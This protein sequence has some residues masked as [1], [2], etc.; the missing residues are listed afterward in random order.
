MNLLM[1]TIYYPDECYQEVAS[2]SKDG[3]QNQINN[4]QKAF[5]EGISACLDPSEKF[6]IINSLPVG[7]FPLQ[8]R[9]LFIPKTIYDEGRVWETGCINF[10]YIKQKM[11]KNRAARLLFRWLK[12]H[13]DNRKVLV[14]TQYLPYLKAIIKAKRKYPDLT[15]A[16]IVTDLPNQYGLDSGRSGLLKKIEQRM[17][18]KQ[19]KL[20]QQI[21]GFVL[22]TEHMV[23][24]L[25]CENK[26]T[27]VIEGLIQQREVAELYLAMDKESDSFEVLY[28][29]TLSPE[30]G[31]QE[32]LDA[33]ATM[34]DIRLRICGGGVMAEQ[35]RSFADQYE[36]IVFEGF[37]PQEKALALQ[38]KANALINPR[39]PAGKFTR[40]SFPSKTLEY[41]RSGK[42]VLCYRL[43]GIP[44]E[45][46]GY[47]NY[48]PSQDAAGIQQAVRKLMQLSAEERRQMGERARV[49][50][51][52]HK[53][54]VAQCHKLVSWL[55]SL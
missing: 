23:E 12:A 29:G 30:L 35:V 10:P 11:R 8:Y 52:T 18:E 26:K 15:A 24:V 55:R 6:Q 42:P 19:L 37:V 53:N 38:T 27:M 43:D 33:F 49:F 45:Y 20:L 31:I 28:T 3:M 32:M 46:D 47:L 25:P 50:V 1:M 17:G 22:L 36:N 21:D 48:I 9:K 51:L 44:T 5:I 4:Y 16:V 7:I 41:M 2:L 40:Y 39:T 34:P 54:P 14:Y 13:P